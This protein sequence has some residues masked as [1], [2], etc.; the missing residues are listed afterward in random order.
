MG[1]IT[2]RAVKPA[3]MTGAGQAM[4]VAPSPARGSQGAGPISRPARAGRAD[5][6]G[7]PRVPRHGHLWMLRDG[8][9]AHVPPGRLVVSADGRL[10]CHLCGRWFTHLGAHLRRHGW[11]AAQYRDAV[12]LP[13]H[14]PL[15]SEDMSGQ[16]AARQK[17]TWE[18]SAQARARFEPGRLLARTGELS[19]LSAAASRE[20]DSSGQLPDAVRAAR[21]QCLAEGRATQA[22]ERQARLDASVAAAGATDLPSL[23]RARYADGFSLD[24]LGR[25]TG[26]GRSRLRAELVAAGVEI[27]PPGA[28]QPTSKHARAERND[29]LT[30]AQVGT[31]DIRAWLLPRYERGVTLRGLAM[32]VNRS[33][34]WVRSRLAGTSGR[35]QAGGGDAREPEPSPPPEPGPQDPSL[36]SPAPGQISLAWGQSLSYQRMPKR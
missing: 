19:R 26:L 3:S 15:C 6:G 20:R 30:A 5:G 23:L 12:E 11:T 22:R 34:P 10:A 33:I 32:E 2:E 21:E 4:R 35:Q 8:T 17:R 31:P 24:Q 27:R 36:P 25:L 7:S 14:T 1:D 29:A 16:I 9:P 18:A 13:L 28:N